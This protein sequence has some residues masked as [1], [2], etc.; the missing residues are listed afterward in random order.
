MEGM[1]IYEYRCENDHIF[2]KFQKID[3][4][5]WQDCEQCGAKAKRIFSRFGTQRVWNGTGVYAFD[6]AGRSPDWQR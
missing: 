3:D 6:R 4:D 5:R 2:E 1:P